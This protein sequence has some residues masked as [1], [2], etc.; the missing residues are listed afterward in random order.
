MNDENNDD[1]KQDTESL[2]QEITQNNEFQIM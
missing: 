2:E 1:E